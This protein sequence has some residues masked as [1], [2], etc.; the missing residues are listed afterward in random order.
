MKKGIVQV[1]C[2][3]GSGKSACA[4]GLAVKAAGSNQNIV[5]I[6]FLKGK[7]EEGEM[8]RRL[9]PEI[10]VF[11]FEKSEK[12][13]C[14]LSEE[15]KKEEASNMRNGVNFAKKVLSTRD[16]DVLILDE[17]LGLVDCG[18]IE[19]ADIARLLEAKDEDVDVIM[20]GIVF[21]EELNSC[22]DRVTRIDS[23]DI[24]NPETDAE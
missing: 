18:I 6:Q 9:E 21:P 11:S 16:C 12:P 23:R 1:L 13:F 24:K 17:I 2:G 7:N 5:I 4:I 14:Q 8:S 19:A 10:K 22:V 15:E 3:E 20:T